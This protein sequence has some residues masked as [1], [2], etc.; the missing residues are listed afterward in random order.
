MILSTSKFV[1]KQTK[2]EKQREA[3]DGNIWDSNSWTK[4][5]LIMHCIFHIGLVVAIIQFSFTTLYGTN[6]F[7]FIGLMKIL[8]MSLQFI[9]DR[10]YKDR[11]L[12]APMLTVHTVME[13]IVTFGAIDFLDFLVGNFVD[14]GISNNM[15]VTYL[16]CV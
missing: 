4:S 2:E 9:Y 7:V 1:K 14:L 16:Y 15:N 12:F 8:G 6:V 10:I 13:S 11:L 5:A 3:Y